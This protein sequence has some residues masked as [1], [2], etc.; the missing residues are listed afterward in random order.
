MKS[1]SHL[2]DKEL[3]SVFQSGNHHAYEI[4]YN[5]YW[6]LLYRHENAM[7]LRIIFLFWQL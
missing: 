1:L 3:L 6:K 4:I 7:L 5:R 2:S